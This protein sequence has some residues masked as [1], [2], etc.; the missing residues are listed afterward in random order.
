MILLPDI[1]FGIDEQ[2]HRLSIQEP[3]TL[4]GK[5][6][7]RM[8][9]EDDFNDFYFD[10]SYYN[11]N[12]YRRAYSNRNRNRNIKIINEND[13][14]IRISFEELECNFRREMHNF[15]NRY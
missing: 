3:Y 7:I 13:L 5:L 6:I 14:I 1:I 8:E 4:D 2:E 10:Y 15:I 9:I 11:D 12:S